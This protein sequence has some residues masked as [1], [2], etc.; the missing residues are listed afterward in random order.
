MADDLSA[1]DANH[2]LDALEHAH[3]PTLAVVY[4]HLTG[5]TRFLT[6]PRFK[7]EYVPIAGDPNGGLSEDAKKE[8]R[9][10]V[11]D[12]MLAYSKSGQLPPAPGKSTLQMMMDYVATAPIPDEYHPFLT[13]ELPLDG[14]DR[15]M[16]GH[17]IR[18]DPS[19]AKQHKMLIIGAGMSGILAGIVFKNQ[20]IPF[21][22]LEKNADLGGTWY[23]NTYP[24][25]RVDSPNH[26]YSY[27][28]EADHDWPHH[29]STQE[30]LLSYFNK[31]A[32]KYGIR[33]HI[34]FNTEVT[35]ATWSD[36][37]NIWTVTTLDTDGTEEQLTSRG[38]VSA[39]G[40]LNQPSYP[41]IKGTD[42]FQ[43]QIFHSARWDHSVDLNGKRVGV[44]GTGASAFQFVPE[45]SPKVGSMTVF[46]RTAGWMAPTPEYHEALTPQKLHLLQNLPFYQIWYRFF[47]FIAMGDAPL[48]YLAKDP[49][50]H[51]YD[52]APNEMGADLR[53]QIEAYIAEQAG[54]DD[55][56][57]AALMPNFQISGK[58]SL[59]DNGIWAGTLKQ[60]HVTLE[61]N[62]IREIT[63]TGIITED[64][65]SHE[66][67]VLI[68]GT[69]FKAQD[70]LFPMTIKG[71]N[72]RDL[73]EHWDG[74]AR[75]YKGVT[76]PGFPN[77]YLMYGPNT[78]IVVNA[79]IIFFS[80]SEAHYMVELM[81]FM[82]ENSVHAADVTREAHD[83][84]NQ[85][86][87]AA[88]AEMPWGYAQ[89]NSW[90]R[91]DKGRVAQNWP[92]RLID[93][94][95]QSREVKPEAYELLK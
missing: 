54:E 89:A 6:D 9:E 14:V 65:V 95:N 40:Q 5:D 63:P 3:H 53:R 21:E 88:N 86:I 78:N 4:V 46:Q 93:F 31:M 50:W 90:Y 29:F 24:G 35:R 33:E 20:G 16:P 2:L 84:Y 77:L 83:A 79:S 8:L 1:F 12:A 52:Y 28:F 81:N 76:V 32:D 47:L 30:H 94:W 37:A 26:I 48:M 45:I 72:G 36:A 69:G 62:G 92:L 51:D 85:F 91:N 11:A 67:D 60:D 87:D 56:L 49:E 41:D 73:H 19:W 58:R 34:R 17:S 18:I 61:T 43:G 39:V 7:P 57:R 75:A 80:E 82:A 13:Q 44:I 38:V 64:G 70:F 25:C 55:R 42:S 74:D 59:R 66:F 27:S 15:R 10:E 22:I 68:Y 71:R 23:D